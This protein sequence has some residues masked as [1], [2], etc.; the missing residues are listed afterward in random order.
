MELDEL[1]TWIR[2]NLADVQVV[3]AS[4]ENGAPEG[5]W[6]DIFVQHDVPTGTKQGSRSPRSSSRINP[7]SMTSRG[8][9]GQACS[10]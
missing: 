10:A 3:V 1:V 2:T 6:G 5:S 8:S 9:T 7:G 4:E